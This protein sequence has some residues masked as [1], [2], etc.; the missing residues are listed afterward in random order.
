[1]PPAA[2]P[3]KEFFR[4][5]WGG[6]R[7]GQTRAATREPVSHIRAA[8]ARRG[9]PESAP[10]AAAVRFCSVS[11]TLSSLP[12]KGRTTAQVTSPNAGR[13]KCRSGR[14]A[15]HFGRGEF[16]GRPPPE[17][18]RDARNFDLPALG[19]VTFPLIASETVHIFQPECMAA[20]PPD[21][22][23]YFTCEN[24]D[25][26]IIFANAVCERNRRMLSAR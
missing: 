22:L 19:E 14:A 17:I 25:L 12:Q 7:D 26:A 13:S 20:I 23:R 3:A 18:A 9:R 2:H 15:R 16:F 11:G 6:L 5:D 4:S 24:P 21:R 10:S 8:P 1:M